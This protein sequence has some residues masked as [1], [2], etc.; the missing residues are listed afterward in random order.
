MLV[1]YEEFEQ[2]NHVK[3][4]V[5]T[6][7]VHSCTSVQTTVYTVAVN[8]KLT[9]HFHFYDRGTVLGRAVKR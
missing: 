3:Y 5:A 9:L 2:V 8:K 7:H 1:T 6:I 4:I